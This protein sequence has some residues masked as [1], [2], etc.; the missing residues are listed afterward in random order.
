M[1]PEL[2]KLQIAA[3]FLAIFLGPVTAVLIT[4][5][6]QRRKEKRDTKI[7]IFQTLM[8]HRKSSPPHPALVEVLNVLDVVF[9][10]TTE[11]VRLWHEYYDLTDTRPL[12]I[13]AMNHKYTDLLFAIAQN[14]GYEKLKQTDIDKFY[15][16][17]GI[18]DQ[19]VLQ[20]EIQ[21]EFLRVLKNTSALV[22]TKKTD[23]EPRQ[24]LY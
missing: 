17:Q 5:W 12:N 16:P 2:Y 7:R 11:V 9:A 20:N 22:V 14:L 23:D 8:A 24:P 10:D 18:A 3:N 1:T 13:Q 15:T 21:Q 19:Y 6:Y 4:L